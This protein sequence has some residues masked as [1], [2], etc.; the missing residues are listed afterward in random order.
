MNSV[1]VAYESFRRICLR[2]YLLDWIRSCLR[3]LRK[4]KFLIKPS[5]TSQDEI[6]KSIYQESNGWRENARTSK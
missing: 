4:R 6:I 1:A 3:K 2:Y 5:N